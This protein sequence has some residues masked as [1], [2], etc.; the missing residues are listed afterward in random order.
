MKID[1]KQISR[2]LESK[3]CRT[4]NQ[5]PTA[6]VVGQKIEFT[7]CCEKF[8]KELEDFPVFVLPISHKI[9]FNE[10]LKFENKIKS[11]INKNKNKTT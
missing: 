2:T 8:K 3:R 5:K 6:K 11:F 9:M 10:T 1:L 7:C 4:H